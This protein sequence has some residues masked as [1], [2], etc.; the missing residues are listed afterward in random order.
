MENVKWFVRVLMFVAYLAVV[1]WLI[2]G[3]QTLQG[4]GNLLQ[5]AGKDIVWISKLKH[6]ENNST[7]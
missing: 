1:A 4:T 3:C 7:D 2:G 6:S 5:G